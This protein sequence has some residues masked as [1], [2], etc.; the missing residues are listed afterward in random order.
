MDDS[1]P[2][3]IE[4]EDARGV[5]ML[6]SILIKHDTV[7]IFAGPQ[8]CPQQREKIVCCPSEEKCTGRGRTYRYLFMPIERL[9]GHGMGRRLLAFFS[10]EKQK[11][12][13]TT[14]TPGHLAPTMQVACSPHNKALL[15]PGTSIPTCRDRPCAACAASQKGNRNV[16]H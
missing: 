12:T 9:R 14:F 11:I 8:L 3:Q 1:V 15:S 10:K 13:V 16:H 2:P 5:I 7:H 6:S 4:D